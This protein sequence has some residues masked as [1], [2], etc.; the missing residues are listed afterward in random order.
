LNRPLDTICTA[1]TPEG[2][3]ISIRPAG[4]PV[5]A[6]A[7][8][9]DVVLQFVAL[10]VLSSALTW[11]GGFGMGAF[12]ILSFATYWFY[13]VV[14]ELAAGAA[15]PGKRIMRLTVLMAD[16]L[17]ITPAGSL[18]RNLMRVVDLLPALYGFGIITI[19]TRSDARRL[20]DIAGGTLVAYRPERQETRFAPGTPCPPRVALTER[21][22]RAISAFAAR[23]ERLTPQRAEEI[24]ALAAR[25][26]RP[27]GDPGTGQESLSAQLVSL[28]RWLH[29]ERSA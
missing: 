23:V 5:R 29:G 19:L 20:G 28:A 18:I 12:F 2:I 8:L 1:E 7:Y 16:G 27:L 21:Q 24:A 15:T 26:L 25:Q 13:P 11:S 14:F 6:C 10:G 22:Q 3:E 17:P 4:Y 9:I